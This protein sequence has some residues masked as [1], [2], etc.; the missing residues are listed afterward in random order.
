MTYKGKTDWKYDDIVT[1]HDLNRIE[2]GIEDVAIETEGKLSALQGEVEQHGHRI[3]VVEE[4]I[5]SQSTKVTELKKRYQLTEAAT[6]I[7]I[8]IPEF[9]RLTDSL[10][11][12]QNSIVLTEGD[13][14]TISEDNLS[15]IGSWDGSEEPI[16]FEFKVLKNFVSDLAFFDGYIIQDGTVDKSKLKRD[17]QEQIDS[18]DTIE[19]NAKAYTDQQ[20]Q[21]VT[22]TGIPKLVTYPYVLTATEDGQTDFVIPLETF[23][24]DT[25]TVMVVK[26]STVLNAERFSVVDRTVRLNVGVRAGAKIFIQVFKNVP[27]GPEGAINGGVIAV[28]SLP[29]DRVQGFDELFTSV[30]EGKG[31]LE[32]TITDMDG[33]VSKQ[34]DVATFDELDEGIRSIPQ[35]KGNATRADVLVGKT[36]SSEVAGIEQAGTMVDRGAVNQTITTQDGQYTIPQGYHSG[37]G[38]VTASFANLTASNVKQGVNIGGVVGMLKEAPNGLLYWAGQEEVNFVP[39]Y[40]LGNGTRS[41]EAN[42]LHLYV[43]DWTTLAERTYVTNTPVNLDGIKAI[44][45]EWEQTQYSHSMRALCV[46]TDKEGDLTIYS[47]RLIDYGNAN[48]RLDRLDVSTLSGSYYIRVHAKDHVDGEA[49]DLNLYVYRIFLMD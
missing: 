48:R 10:T 7:P 27:L 34:G 24:K 22:E 15:I 37:T 18:I 17:V 41:K 46:S 21:L 32:A 28:N 1:E 30:S 23:D 31:K 47:T 33:E 42:R 29:S 19:A 14:Y 2:Q 38:R 3:T 12:I 8:G 49:S 20:I 16:D 39:G 13:Q 44:G 5:A 25:D 43:S 11:V 9:H 4:Q 45:I 6:Q 35:A 26:N 36:F 40:E